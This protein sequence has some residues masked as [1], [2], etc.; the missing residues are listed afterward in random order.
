VSPEEKEW[1]VTS[2]RPVYQK[3]M[4]L[5][6][7]DVTLPTGEHTT[8]AVDDSQET[9]VATLLLDQGQIV[10]SRQY[11]FPLRQWI[12]DL[13]G[14]AQELGETVEEAAIRECR[15]EIGLEPRDL[16]P[17]ASFYPNPGRS[18]WANQLF[19]SDSASPSL[20]NTGDPSEVVRAV[21]MDI[22]HALTLL[23]RG[24]ALDAGLAIAL[25]AAVRRRLI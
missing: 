4:K 21:R 3:Y 22:A 7:Y 5:N 18:R 12:W 13:P 1:L 8:Y 25:H 2:V 14:G 16:V 20:R 9:A 10:L 23:D 11:R 15:E 19:F 24:E 6:E 17:L